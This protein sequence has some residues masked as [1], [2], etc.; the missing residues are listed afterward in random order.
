[1]LEKGER[2]PD[3]YVQIP[4]HLIFDVKFDGR[5]KCRLVAGGHRTPDVPPE[6]VYSGD[7]SMNTIRMVLC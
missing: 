7:V 4:Y 3:G 1:M 5:R 6:E 2:V